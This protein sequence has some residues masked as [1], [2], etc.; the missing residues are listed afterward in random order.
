[1]DVNRILLVVFSFLAVAFSFNIFSLPSEKAAVYSEI[2][3]LGSYKVIAQG[4]SG[5][6]YFEASVKLPIRFACV[7]GYHTEIELRGKQ[8]GD[9]QSEELDWAVINNQKSMRAFCK[10]SYR[11]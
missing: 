2:V 1:M 3:K 9:L 11:G 6:G 4:L 5:Y 7:D 10:F 8:L